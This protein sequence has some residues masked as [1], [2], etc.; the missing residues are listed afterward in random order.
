MSNQ[1]TRSS[2]TVANQDSAFHPVILVCFVATV[3]YLTAR[4]GDALVLRPQM[5]W[6][7]WPGCAFL[8]AVLLL[9]PRKIWPVLLAAG[10]AG[11]V[12]H[13]LRAGVAIRTLAL[14][15]LADMIE[16]LIAAWCVSLAFGGAPRL[17]SVKS[18]AKYSFIGVILAS[19]SAASLSATVLGADYWLAWRISF[20]TEALALLT[21]TPAILSWAGMVLTREKMSR[22]YYLEGAVLLAGLAILGYTTFV[23]SNV[24]S[25]S[26]LLY[27]LVPFLLWSA[28]RFGTLGVSSSMMV[29]A[30]LSIWGAIHGHGPF[31]G[32]APLSNVLT[33]QIFLLFAA[34]SFMV[35][36]A[37]VEEHKETVQALL[38]S[39][40]RFRL[41][42]NAAPVMIWM[43]GPDKFF[44]Y[45]NQ[46]WLEFTGRSLEAALG[47]GWA[48]A[49]HAEDLE[50]CLDTYTT[51]FGRRE[52]FE[53]EYRLQRH[54]GECRWVLDL[55]V[56]RFNPDG[57]F[58]GYIGSCIDVTER[59][60]AQEALSTVSRRLLE[61]HEEE[62]T[63]LARELHDD[64]NQRIAF[65][66]VTLDA[67]KRE[68]PA[69]ATE[70]KQGIGD[71]KE[72]VA[73]IGHDI[74]ALSH[75]LHSSKLEY[76]GLAV[77][78]AG[79][80]REFSDQQR[81]EIAFHSDGVPK[82][83]PPEISLCLFRVLQ[84]ALQNA[85]KHS[86]SRRFEVS[87]S[88]TSNE[89]HLSVRDSGVGF[90]P[91]EAMKG[92]GLGITSMRERLKLVHGTFSI[93]S[94][95][96]RGTT[97]HARVPLSSGT[98]PLP[99]FAQRRLSESAM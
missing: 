89:I 38:E 90:D 47:N 98:H 33:L 32:G 51:A 26:V 72:R 12:L 87:L 1:R 30:S 17:N 40:K 99:A 53:R 92:R 34:T 68:L 74:Q 84:E 43:S 18:L 27:S 42:A 85:T 3:S 78:A 76:L 5:I 62:R 6:P 73:D 81:V 58:A 91:E 57:S 4:L 7:L 86:R 10:L 55:G 15:N 50:R 36:A 83:L 28:L 49:V 2:R 46:Q 20:L 45:F 48:Q 14:L 21:L 19:I 71:V 93:A 66:A 88:C 65:V 39:E 79:F 41:V 59:K 70:A 97:V 77:A 63:R 16:V 80:C 94:Q 61:A 56:P 22:A 75:R 13:D 96:E 44:D 67:L 82:V 69:L 23:A 11:F 35:L 24:R 60:L 95:R 8:V 9:T 29:V 31:V 37:L 25:Y 52:S 54:D 64:I